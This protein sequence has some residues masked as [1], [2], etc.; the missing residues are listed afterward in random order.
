MTRTNDGEDTNCVSVRQEPKEFG[1]AGS[2][3]VHHA[4]LP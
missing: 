2:A 4:L 3:A 1:R